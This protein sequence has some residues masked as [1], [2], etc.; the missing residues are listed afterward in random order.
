MTFLDKYN[1]LKKSIPIP[2]V[3]N[4]EST[5]NCELTDYAWHSKN[6]YYCFDGYRQEDSMYCVACVGKNLVD[7]YLAIECEV[8]YE[9]VHSN[10]CYRS[11]YLFDCDNCNDCLYCALC[12]SCSD[13]FGCVG[14]THKKYCI[15]NK[16][17]SKEEYEVKVKEL[18]KE[19]PE[20][21]LKQIAELKKN[22]PHPASI[23]NN[24]ESCPYGDYI[25]NSK[26]SYWCFDSYYMENCGYNFLS[27]LAKKSWDTLLAGGGSLKTLAS[28]TELTYEIINTEN[29]YNCAYL[30]NCSGCTNCYYSSYLR[31]SSDCFGCVGLSNKKYC[32]LNN[33]LTKEE[34][35]RG[36]KIIKKELGWK[37]E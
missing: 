11:T 18:K 20:Q 34:Y 12:L 36:I 6:C 23:Q 25:Y 35:E 2:A 10:K 24:N 4:V 17:Y 19:N 1:I 22:I 14:L 16:Q 37:S 29:A 13:C 9:C 28:N 21:I 3:F 8:C 31:N 27:G 26:N 5:E 15:F 32:I 30:L 33:Q 7:C